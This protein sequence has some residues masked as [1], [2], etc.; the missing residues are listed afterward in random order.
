MIHCVSVETETGGVDHLLV[1]AENAKDVGAIALK[2]LG[3][4]DDGYSVFVSIN[5]LKSV[6]KNQFNGIAI[7][8]T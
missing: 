3:L 2:Q 8:T 4:I 5:S 7:L 1:Y 6:V